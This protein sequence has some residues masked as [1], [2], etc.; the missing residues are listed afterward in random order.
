[1]L[2][3]L[4]STY[5]VLNPHLVGCNVSI[6]FPIFHKHTVKYVPVCMCVSVCELMW[7]DLCWVLFGFVR[8]QQMVPLRQGPPKLLEL[9]G[10][11]LRIC[12]PLFHNTKIMYIHTKSC[13]SQQQIG[14]GWRK[15]WQKCGKWE[16]MTIRW[17]HF[18]GR[19]M[20]GIPASWMIYG[21]IAHCNPINIAMCAIDENVRMT[22]FKLV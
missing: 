6:Y 8:W 19:E 7:M 2:E 9:A 3:F 22:H 13:S 10:I 18:L 20:G 14:F 16:Q 1:M 5:S 15:I 12:V 21:G 11:R 4:S 17:D